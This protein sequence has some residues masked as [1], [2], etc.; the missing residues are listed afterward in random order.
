MLPTAEAVA[1]PARRMAEITERLAG[2]VLVRP[3][4]RSWLAAT[5][6]AGVF[7]VVFLIAVVAVVAIGVGLFGVNIPVAWAFPIVNTIWWI[8]MAHAGTV[9]SAILM[10][11]RQSWRAPVTRFAE[12]MAMFAVVLAGTFP[13][14]HLGRPWFFYYLLPY[15]DTMKLWPQWRSPLVWDFFAIG[16]YLLYTM[17]FLYLSILPDAA[18]LRDRARTRLGQIF[19]GVLAVGWRN[20]SLHWRRYRQAYLVLAVLAAPIVATVTGTISLDLA[21]SIVPGYHFSIFPPYFVAGALYSGF[22]TVILIAA[23]VRRMF[24]LADVVTVDHIDKLARLMLAFGLVVDYAY[25]MEMFTAWYSGE[26]YYLHVYIDRWTG[27]YAPF[28]WSMIFCNVGLLQLVWFR[29]VRRCVPA[30]TV[31]AIVADLGMWLE[32]YQIVLTSTHAG[33]TP[34]RWDSVWPTL[35]DWAVQFGSIG[36]FFFLLLIFIRVVPPLSMK[37]MREAA[38]EGA[39]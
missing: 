31:L 2:L 26:P 24:G 9:I 5:L 37:D 8:G 17:T 32:R 14:L 1:A 6:L 21:V 39:A 38:H 11:T 10:L 27:P 36:L 20:S 7:T 23:I 25:C 13:L 33:Y 29:R 30:M 16:T 18:A 35:T 12:A 4:P 34:S 19:Y 22:A 3:A 28:W 15:P